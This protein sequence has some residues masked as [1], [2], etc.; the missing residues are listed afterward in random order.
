MN[1]QSIITVSWTHKE[2]WSYT[3]KWGKVDL[4]AA[5]TRIMDE[6]QSCGILPENVDEKLNII[7]MYQ[8]LKD[9]SPNLV[10][11]CGQVFPM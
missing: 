1:P 7:A 6:K 5:A 11:D 2:T 8:H 3:L 10:S 4:H 9:I